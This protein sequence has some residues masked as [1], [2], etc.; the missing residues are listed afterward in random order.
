MIRRCTSLGI[1]YN[2]FRKLLPLSCCCFYHVTEADI[3]GIVC[4]KYPTTCTSETSRKLKKYNKRS[5]MNIAETCYTTC[6]C[7]NRTSSFDNKYFGWI[8]LIRSFRLIDWEDGESV[9]RDVTI[10]NGAFYIYI[11]DDK[12]I[13]TRIY[14]PKIPFTRQ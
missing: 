13:R 2:R 5:Y 14:G 10:S 4:A 6:D 11:L 1:L 12:I 3:N 7:I 9:K 8:K